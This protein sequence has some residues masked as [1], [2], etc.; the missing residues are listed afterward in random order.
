MMKSADQYGIISGNGFDR[1]FWA[2]RA[3]HHSITAYF[4]ATKRV[5]QKIRLY[6]C[7]ARRTCTRKEVAFLKPCISLITP[8]FSNLQRNCETCHIVD[9]NASQWNSSQHSQHNLVVVVVVVVKVGSLELHN[10]T[11]VENQLVQVL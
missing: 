3:W 5:Q 1:L 9:I 6:N 8:H 7:C 11:P 10:T 2:T 4:G